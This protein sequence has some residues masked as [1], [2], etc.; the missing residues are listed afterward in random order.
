MGE[1]VRRRRRPHRWP[2]ARGWVARRKRASNGFWRTE[3]TSNPRS[4]SSPSPVSDSSHSPDHQR[5][6]PGRPA[7]AWMTG[8]RRGR[9]RGEREEGGETLSRGAGGVASLPAGVRIRAEP[10]AQAGAELRR[11][12]A[13]PRRGL[14]GLRRR[15]LAAVGSRAGAVRGRIHVR[16]RGLK[17]R[18][19]LPLLS[20]V[21]SPP[22]MPFVGGSRRRAARNG[23]DEG[24]EGP[25]GARALTRSGQ[26]AGRMF[27]FRWNRLA[28][29]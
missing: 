6:A 1:P 27:W 4:P 19:H 15:E 11:R 28:G 9:W 25:F 29:S 22:S 12:R 24:V 17:Q 23:S 18:G 3:I 20:A 5:L 8:R 10:G 26:S 2:G 13:D 14:L 16:R 21:G 7:P